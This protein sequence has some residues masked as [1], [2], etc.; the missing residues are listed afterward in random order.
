MSAEETS[1]YEFEVNEM[2]KGKKWGNNSNYKRYNPNS[3]CN[4]RP[5]YNKTQENKIGKTWGQKEKDYKITLTQESSHFIPAESSDSF[6]KLFDLA[7]TI[8]KEELKEQGKS[9]TQVNK[10]MVRDMI[11]AFGVTKD[12]MEKAAEI[13]GKDEKTEN[14]GNSSF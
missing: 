14:M 2:S 8:K 11:Q 12:Q 9:S 5:Q 3:N 7:M 13:L 6:F 1:G 4:G 10:M